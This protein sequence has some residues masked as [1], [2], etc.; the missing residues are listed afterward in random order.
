MED[1]PEGAVEGKEREYPSPSLGLV[2]GL[3]K[4]LCPTRCSANRRLE[5]EE[6]G[7]Q[8]EQGPEPRSLRTE[9]EGEPALRLA[10]EVSC[11]Q[12][13]KSAATAE[14]EL[15]E[16]ESA[17]LDLGSFPVRPERP[18]PR[19]DLFCVVDFECTCDKLHDHPHEI[20]EFPAVF[21]NARTLCIEFEFHRFVRPTERPQLTRFCTELTGI[22]QSEVDAA[23]PL[24]DVLAE[25]EAFLRQRALMPKKRVPADSRSFCVATDGPW[26][27][28][29]FLMPECQRKRI[30]GFAKTWQKVVNV[31]R[32]FHNHFRLE[33]GGVRDM[34]ASANLD[35]QG[36][37][38]SGLADSRN[39]ARL[40]ALLLADGVDVQHNLELM[41]PE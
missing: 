26:D 11:T 12:E 38:H 10:G 36:R 40:L 32:R 5:Q 15:T 41:L 17:L 23:S 37:E 2:D 30:V 24:E 4:R 18:R 28:R 31:R 20:I 9:E 8:Q 34:L 14:E 39:I 27:V 1:A 3:R 16:P 6:Q 7:P 21:V 33:G 35:F 25:F 22:Q 29:K 13:A 19:Y